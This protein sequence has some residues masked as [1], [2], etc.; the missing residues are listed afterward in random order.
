M[1]V[2]AMKE[3]EIAF[4]ASFL[5]SF[6]IKKE[7]KRRIS[8]KTR[9]PTGEKIRL[10]RLKEIQKKAENLQKVDKNL[11]KGLEGVSGMRLPK[12]LDFCIIM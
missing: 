10:D 11:Q 3:I 4:N 6:S 5:L 9:S 1:I 8:G 12:P 2:K 7:S